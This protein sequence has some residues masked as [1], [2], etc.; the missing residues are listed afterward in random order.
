MKK[1]EDEKALDAAKYDHL[2]LLAML[3]SSQE[4]YQEQCGCHNGA[5]PP[6]WKETKEWPNVGYCE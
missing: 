6:Y 3:D 4:Q 1:S 2:S 5:G